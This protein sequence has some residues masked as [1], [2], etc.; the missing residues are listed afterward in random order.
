MSEENKDKKDNQVKEAKNKDHLDQMIDE[1]PG[2][3][4]VDFW[5]PSWRPF[6]DMDWMFEDMSWEMDQNVRFIWANIEDDEFKDMQEEIPSNPHYRFFKK[7]KWV[8]HLDGAYKETFK[9]KVERHGKK[10][11]QGEWEEEE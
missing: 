8:D 4:V 11:E 6:R 10:N 1:W 9:E 2:L 3:S 7:N 5:T